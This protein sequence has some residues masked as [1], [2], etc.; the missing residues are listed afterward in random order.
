MR[1]RI[2]LLTAIAATC[3]FF[4]VDAHAFTIEKG[5]ISLGG[6]SDMF[7]G[8]HDSDGAEDI[9]HFQASVEIGYLVMNNLEIGGAVGFG[10]SSSDYSDSTTYSLAPFVTYHFPFNE[11]S[12][13]Y[14][15]GRLGYFRSESDSDDL[16]IESDGTTWSLGA[17]WEYFFNRYVAATIGLAYSE[18]DR[19]EEF[20]FNNGVVSDVVTTDSSYTSF[21]LNFGLRVYFR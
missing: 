3:F 2:V 14:L 8:K 19:D 10:F 9:D 7:L 11:N 6:S 12:N 4:T 13:F 16:S 21:G 5:T 15:T 18:T 1:K 20:E 17:G